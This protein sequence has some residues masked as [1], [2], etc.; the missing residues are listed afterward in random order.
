MISGLWDK[1]LQV[2]KF[3]SKVNDVIYESVLSTMK[4]VTYED[5]IMIL[6]CINAYVLDMAKTN[7]NDSIIGALKTVS[8]NNISVKYVEEGDKNAVLS[9]L[10]SEKKAI[11]QAQDNNSQSIT[12]EFTFANFI[13][14][15]CNRFAQA[16]AMA[17]AN[18]P[19]QKQHNP[20]YLWGNSG[21]GKT[22]L[23]K[24]I[25]YEIKKNFPEKNVLYTTCESFTNAFV[26]CMQEKNYENFRYK[27]RNVDVLII[28]D[29][30]F[31]IGKEGT[32]MEFFNTFEALI[33]AGK[34]IVIT[35]DKA[36]NNLTSLDARLTSRFQ[37]GI[38][39]DIQPPDFETRKV[40]FTSKIN[41]DHI[42]LPDDVINY[43]CENVTSNVRELNGAY[44]I[45][46][47]YLALSNGELDL[48]MAKKLLISIVSPN[49]K[50]FFTSDVIINAVS[51]YF[52]ISPEKIVG[53][54][55][56]KEIVSARAIAMYI[57]RELLEAN[58]D[59]IGSY[60]GDK[61]H[62]T[63]IHSIKNVEES[64]EL[65]AQTK[66]IIKKLTE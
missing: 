54:G 64:E 46:S 38:L 40:I 35:S 3:D 22:H 9:S 60:F 31:L 55:R 34:Q 50:K 28:D 1:A 5:G 20:L 51:K 53:S 23:A 30:Q 58:Y 4:E 21:L 13:V 29:I 19:G 32:Q 12:D 11:S 7:L 6:S 33:N 41:N 36:P 24:A 48:D 27:Y 16:S 43:V 63:V 2:L 37:N 52:D 57:C 59:T 47:S 66:E 45:L 42:S 10:V 17:V 26:A 49:Q 44:N 56:V 61:K 8:G 62:S 39:M 14:G 65:L 25:G 18:N 15:D